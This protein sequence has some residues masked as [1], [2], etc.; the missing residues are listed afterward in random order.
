MP[1]GDDKDC[2]SSLRLSDA[3]SEGGGKNIPNHEP[4]TPDFKSDF[5][6]DFM[7]DFQG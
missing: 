7:T 1:G 6:T 3:G 2:S 4:A 5:T